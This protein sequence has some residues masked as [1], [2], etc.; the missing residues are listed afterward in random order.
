MEK[1]IAKKEKKIIKPSPKKE[2]DVSQL[3]VPRATTPEASQEETDIIDKL[4]AEAVKANRFFQG[5]GR[6]KTSTARVRLIPT[7]DKSITVNGKSHHSYFPLMEHQETVVAP[8]KMRKCLERFGVSVKVQGGGVNSQS[9]AI[10]HGIA[11]ALI[12]FNPD[13]KKRLRRAGYLT[14]D[15]RM[16]E[17]KKFG[18]KRAR[19]APQFSKR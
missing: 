9:Q 8:L 6:R 5:I 14:R 12:E 13:F 17:R 18:L 4:S 10:R 19:R 3:I 1:K 16:R 7:G 11:R 15:P 2:E